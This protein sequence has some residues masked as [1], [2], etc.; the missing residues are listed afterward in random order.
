MLRIKPYH[1]KQSDGW[2]VV[3]SGRK[4]PLSFHRLKST[5]I[6]RARNKAKAQWKKGHKA[7]IVV[8]KRN[9]QIAYEHTYGLDPRRTKG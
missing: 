9:G 4:T 3:R 8:Y 2:A 1:R 5:A 7:Q 6:K